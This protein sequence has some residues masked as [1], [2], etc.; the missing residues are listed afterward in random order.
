MNS[1]QFFSLSFRFFAIQPFRAGA[2]AL[3]QVS[4]ADE[5]QYAQVMA[6]QFA[7]DR[8]SSCPVDANGKLQTNLTA[9]GF[10]SLCTSVQAWGANKILFSNVHLHFLV[11]CA[12]ASQEAAESMQTHYIIHCHC[13]PC[14]VSLIRAG[15]NRVV[16]SIANTVLCSL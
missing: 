2:L 16:F 13:W 8:L 4:E 3:H 10:N 9:S 6:V 1:Q 15:C 14:L 7:C 11:P 12:H 5:G